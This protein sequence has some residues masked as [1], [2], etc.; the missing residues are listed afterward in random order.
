MIGAQREEV[1]L[2][3]PEAAKQVAVS[4]R[5]IQRWFTDGL[6]HEVGDDRRKRVTLANLQAYVRALPGMTRIR[7]ARK[8]TRR[9]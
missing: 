1:K 2:T 3:I 9:G 6:A 4:E 8:A 5:T 7:R